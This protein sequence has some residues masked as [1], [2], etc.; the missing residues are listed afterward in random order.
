MMKKQVGLN[1]VS[2]KLDEDWDKRKLIRHVLE[3][4]KMRHILKMVETIQ[5]IELKHI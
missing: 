5:S 4:K 2:A 1:F 3:K